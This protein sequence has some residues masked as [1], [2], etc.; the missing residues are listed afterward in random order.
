MSAGLVP[1]SIMEETKAANS[2]GA[3]PWFD[4]SSVWM[5][6]KPKNGCFSFSM[7]PYMCTPQ[8]LQAC[9]LMTAF[10]STTANLSSLA[11]TRTL[12]RGTTATWE[13]SAPARFPHLVHPHTRLLGAWLSIPTPH[14]PS[15]QGQTTGPP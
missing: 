2:G 6:S 5:K 11:V 1:D 13:N 3:Q 8:L 12:P 7:R 4:E 14:L 15:G 10:G 9:R